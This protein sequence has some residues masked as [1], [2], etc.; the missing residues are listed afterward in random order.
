[1]VSELEPHFT[2]APETKFEPFTVSVKPEPPLA[3]E[4]GDRLLIEGPGGALD[5]QLRKRL[6]TSMDPSPVTKS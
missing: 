1:V 4:D 3:A 5:D 2:T 6:S